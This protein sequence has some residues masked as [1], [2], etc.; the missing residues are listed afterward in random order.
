MRQHPAQALYDQVEDTLT[1][2]TM[3]LRSAIQAD[4]ST[5]TR[6]NGNVNGASGRMHR[7]SGWARK[8]A[9]E[10]GSVLLDTLGLATTIE[11]HLHQFQKCTGTRYEL[12]VSN[13]AGFDPP[14]EHAAAIFEIYSEAL[15]NVARH[16]GASRVTIVLT[17][18]PHE[19][20]LVV[21]DDGIG[22]G[23]KVSAS[24]AGGI[25]D[26]R[27]RSHAFKG[28]CEVTAARNGGTAVAASLPMPWTP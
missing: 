8:V 10:L 19:V 2:L 16:S 18:T 1:S 27:A 20:S 23:N 17:I 22:P 13:A 12:T 14:E 15:S 24:N 11:W 7:A 3:Q 4:A 6:V 28:S 26:M 9:T 25:A 5:A 21:A